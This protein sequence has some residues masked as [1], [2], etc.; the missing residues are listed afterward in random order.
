[1]RNRAKIEGAILSARGW[2]ELMRE[3]GGFS[4]FLWQF[5]DGTGRSST[6]RARWPTSRAES[7]EARAM[8]KALKARGF[9]FVGPTICYAF[10]QAIGMVDDHVVDCFRHG[11]VW[12]PNDRD[13]RADSAGHTCCLTDHVL[14]DLVPVSCS[15]AP[16]RQARR[17]YDRASDYQNPM[18][19]AIKSVASHHPKGRMMS[20]ASWHDAQGHKQC[21]TESSVHAISLAGSELLFRVLPANTR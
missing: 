9:K 16:S 6:T 7:A 2:L 3:D 15:Q 14:R 12:L 5:V 20:H 21:R 1:M 13:W 8:S 11:G 4:G 19:L 18:T 10:M 17:N